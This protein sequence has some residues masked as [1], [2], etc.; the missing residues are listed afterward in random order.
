[1]NYSDPNTVVRC[2]AARGLFAIGRNTLTESEFV[3]QAIGFWWT[4][5]NNY[6]TLETEQ[7]RAEIERV[8][9]CFYRSYREFVDSHKIDDKGKSAVGEFNRR[10]MAGEVTKAMDAL[11][12]WKSDYLSRMDAL[13]R[14]FPVGANIDLLAEL[15]ALALQAEPAKA[16]IGEIE[17]EQDRLAAKGQVALANV[18]REAELKQLR[19]TVF[20]LNGRMKEVREEIANGEYQ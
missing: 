17:R 9:H 20:Q 18:H 13:R 6:L 14:P 4:M 10:L 16:L 19:M 8:Y 11:N 15:E 5:P 12:R 7:H 1:M 2:A 3:E